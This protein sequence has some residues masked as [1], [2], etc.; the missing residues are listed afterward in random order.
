VEDPCRLTAVRRRYALTR[1]FVLADGLKNPEL[2]IQAWRRLPPGLRADRELVFF[3]RRS[4]LLRVVHEAV[5]AREACLLLSPPGEDLIAL[6]SLADAFV[7]PSWIEGFG[8]PLLE[9]M[10]CG[11]PVIA[12]DRGAIPEVAGDAAL[13][14]D[15]EDPTTLADHLARVLGAPEEAERLR[16]RGFIRA[17]QYSWQKSARRI[18]DSYQMVLSSSPIAAEPLLQ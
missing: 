8:L 2:L 18:L 9:A 7:Y 15:A 3:S 17:R 12:S 1:P 4:D 13:L 16:Q 5:A 10:A 11:T 6:Y 14:A